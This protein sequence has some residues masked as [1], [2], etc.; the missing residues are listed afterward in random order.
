MSTESK[1]ACAE[2]VCNPNFSNTTI[3]QPKKGEDITLI[4]LQGPGVFIAAEVSKQGGANGVTFVS[5]VIDG[6]PVVNKSYAGAKN[7]GLT[8]YNPFGIVLLKTNAFDNF[9]IGFPTPLRFERELV[10]SVRVD[11]AD[12]LQI[13]ARVV[14]G[15]A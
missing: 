7:V 11:E 3:A 1:E 10:L 12:V 15:S 5:L 2:G 13:V 8:Q 6:R 4:K 14:H 9:T